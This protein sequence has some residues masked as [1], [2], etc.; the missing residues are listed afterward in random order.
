MHPRLDTLKKIIIDSCFAGNRTIISRSYCKMHPNLVNILMSCHVINCFYK[1]ETHASFVCLMSNGI[2]CC[3]KTDFTIF[4]QTLVQFL[5]FS[6]YKYQNNLML[7]IFLVFFC[8]VVI[9]DTSFIFF[10]FIFNF[11][12]IHS[13][14][15]HLPILPIS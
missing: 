14:L 2:R 13:F 11:Y 5:K 15:F 9:C 4:F 10:H 3:H 6:I 8:N 7:I 12:M 1:K